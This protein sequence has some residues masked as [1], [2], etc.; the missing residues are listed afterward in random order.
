M[1]WVIRAFWT[2]C[3]RFGLW[4][5]YKI[6]V[7]GLEN[8]NERTL[9]RPGGTLFLANHP[10]LMDP[11]MLLRI[12]YPQYKVHAIAADFLERNPLV[13]SIL[14]LY[15]TLFIPGFDFGSNSFK[16]RKIEKTYQR[17]EE[18]L[19]QGENILIYPSGMLKG[20]PEEIIG[21]NSGVHDLL[22]KVPYS[23]IVLVRTTGMWGSMFSKALTGT[24][25]KLI[26]AFLKGIKIVLK[27]GIFFAPRRKVTIEC[28]P[29]PK[30]FPW[31]A[32]R[33]TFN[34][35]LEDWYNKNGPEP[36]NLVSFSRLGVYLPVVY[37]K[38]K[39]SAVNLDA[40]PND[41]KE[42]VIYE[43]AEIAHLP[44][45]QVTPDQDL[46]YD[47]GLDS[48]DR[49]Q[50]LLVLKD[51]F[52]IT[53][54]GAQELT[55]VG[56]VMAYAARLKQGK[57]SEEQSTT[58]ILRWHKTE[59][60]PP[61]LYLDDVTTIIEAFLKTSFR[62]EGH[63]AA[64]DSMIGEVSY[65]RLR[66][67][68]ILFAGKIQQMPGETI[69]IMMPASIG[70]SLL[71][72]A[73]QLAGKV[74]V[75]IN[76]TL[77]KSNL[78]AVLEQTKLQVVLSSW[79]FLDLLPNVELGELNDHIVLIEKWKEEF[80]LVQKLQA[81]ALSKKSPEKI[82]SHFGADTIKRDD[83]AVVLFTSGTE[84]TPKGVPLSHRNIIENQRDALTLFELSPSDAVLGFLPPFHSFGFSITGMLPLV[85]GW[86]VVYYPNPT[87][88]KQIVNNIY[89]WRVTVVCSAPTFM[90]S[91]LRASTAEK[92]A[93]L[94]CIV[95]GA[96]KTPQ[97]LFEN[98]RKLNPDI[99]VIEGYGITECSPILTINPIHQQPI[100]VGQP[101]P[102]VRI[103]IVSAESLAPI[104]QGESGLI[105]ASG[106]NIFAGYLD[107]TNTSPFIQ[108][109]GVQW[110]N[111]G[112]LGYLD[113]GG[114]LILSGRL[115]RF[116]KI[117]GEMVSLG[118]V[119]H[120]LFE[121]G[122][123]RGWSFD[124]EV[125]TLAVIAVEKEGKKGE[126]HL[127]TT[128]PAEKS[129]LNSFLKE[130]GMSNLIR[131][132]KVHKVHVIPTLGTGKVDYQRLAK[133]LEETA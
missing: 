110:Y 20:Q 88:S 104:A 103:K 13:R 5:R 18:L 34:R 7:K 112:D 29:A 66:L 92:V 14:K 62:M 30:N 38:P 73:V 67:G 24:S 105:L 6:V 48:L 23:N 33:R 44:E 86:R 21:G 39:E 108:Q 10:A 132:H 101:L 93:S 17:I 126:L 124:P 107:T 131:L 78:D 35:Y 64:A 59:N 98:A 57:E 130:Y 84:S 102:Q 56:M 47:L 72:L 19:K 46:A 60:R 111:T 61:I 125:S 12:F 37:Q 99:E 120:A 121:G 119:E 75:M 2:C 9:N 55:T 79:Q 118:A 8:I 25:P 115:K 51:H 123:K 129:E 43:I 122:K 49:S 133:K 22:K 32:D 1:K 28:E 77:G 63:I 81:K 116:I 36:L 31:D 114:N 96:E 82:L 100:G 41:I 15:G 87:A 127:F 40:V 95:C 4:L 76:W 83:R 58:K 117:G 42:Q 16:Q 71:T 94:R 106:P 74:P 26:P 70:A 85:S 128:F 50:I 65:E 80:T 69:G 113:Q 54:V 91:I 53:N 27:N 109:D 3:F 52:G 11:I 90:K 68:V 89:R 45:E 97:E